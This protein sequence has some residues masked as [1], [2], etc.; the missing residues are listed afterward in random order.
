M[1]EGKWIRFSDR[2]PGALRYRLK[3]VNKLV[4]LLDIC[5]N[6]CIGCSDHIDEIKKLSVIE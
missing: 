5:D 6:K 4:K 3:Q 2:D 1:K